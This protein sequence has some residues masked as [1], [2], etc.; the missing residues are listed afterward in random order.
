MSETIQQK[1]PSEA[2]S[3]ERK[4]GGVVFTPRFDIW[5][6]DDELLLYGDLPG[7][8]SK[9][10]DIRFEDNQLNLHGRVA[11]RQPDV[12]YLYGEYAIGDFHRSFAI[13]E[14]I[15]SSRISAE[16]KNGVL[17]L[18]LPKS[19]AVKPRRIQVNTA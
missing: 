9:D 5:E 10:L 19:E 14:A 2:E 17:K 4:H 6:N 11:L 8:D 1:Q 7:V 15:D 16:L 12:Q 3:G 18:R 13:G